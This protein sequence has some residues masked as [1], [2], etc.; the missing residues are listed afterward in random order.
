[1][2]YLLLISCSRR[3]LRAG[4]LLPALDRYDGGV[5]RVVRK[6]KR[7]GTLRPHLDIKIVSAKFGLIDGRDRIP[8]YD[9]RMDKTRAAKVNPQVR[10]A[11]GLA[12]AH[13]RYSEIYIDLGKDY[14]PAVR[15]LVI[16][17]E[18]QQEYAKG[19]IGQRLSALKKWL[20]A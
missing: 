19:R 11:L 9:Q 3:K 14:L 12:F 13:A 2:K 16:P 1:V 7:D 17:P 8:Y 10:R 5:Y 18:V 20:T 4:S 15:G 6:T